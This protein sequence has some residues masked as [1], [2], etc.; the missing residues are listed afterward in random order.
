MTRLFGIMLA[1]IVSLSLCFQIWQVY[2]FINAGA[3]FTA[4][5][6]QSLCERVAQLENPPGECHYLEIRK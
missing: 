5:D 2:R 3:R 6:G 4:A 1:V